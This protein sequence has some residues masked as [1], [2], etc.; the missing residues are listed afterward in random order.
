MEG[1]GGQNRRLPPPWENKKIMLKFILYSYVVHHV[2][3]INIQIYKITVI[4]QT[5]KICTYCYEYVLRLIIRMSL[6]QV[7]I[8]QN[9]GVA[10]LTIPLTNEL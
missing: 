9:N 2:K 6:H 4:I 7:H 3:C 8:L 1:G 5:H 10:E